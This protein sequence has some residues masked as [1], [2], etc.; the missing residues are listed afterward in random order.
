MTIDDVRIYN[1]A[2]SPTEAQ[3]LYR[4]HSLELARERS[5]LKTDADAPWKASASVSGEAR[6]QRARQL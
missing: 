6:D 1:R 4:S 3:T 2:L 5:A